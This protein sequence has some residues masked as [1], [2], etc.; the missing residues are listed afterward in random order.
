MPAP[1]WGM[2][3]HATVLTCLRLLSVAVNA[4]FYVIAARVVGAAA[5]GRAAALIGLVA[6][7][8]LLLDAGTA[9]AATRD[10]AGQDVPASLAAGLHWRV[11]GAVATLTVAV[12]LAGSARLA[13]IGARPAVLVVAVLAW[14]WLASCP[15]LVTGVLFGHARTAVG[16][17][18][19][20]SE[21]VVALTVFLAAR[22]AIPTTAGMAGAAAAGTVAGTAVAVLACRATLRTAWSRRGVAIG[23]Q[24]RRS[25]PFFISGIGAQLQNL[26]IPL[27]AWLAGPAAAG[28]LAAPSRMTTPLGVLAASA[29][30]VVLVQHRH[31][32]TGS[33]RAGHAVRATAIVVTAL[34]LAGVAPLLIAPA[35]TAEFLFGPGFSGGAD[36]FRLVAIGVCLSALSQPLAADLQARGRQS[37]VAAAV[38]SGGFAGTVTVIVLAPRIGALGGGVGILVAQVVVAAALLD[39][40]RGRNRRPEPALT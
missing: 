23:F 1:A 34:T 20:L 35:Q 17:A 12:M 15:P 33:G 7:L 31:V 38:L 11:R 32:G 24:L 36:V 3:R 29:S 4:A 10:A 27:V 6:V 14:S 26:D 22:H 28:L 16:A 8:S 18:A 37:R 19:G 40:Y 39:C 13:G 21:K 30:V 25:W 2:R 9:T 5:F